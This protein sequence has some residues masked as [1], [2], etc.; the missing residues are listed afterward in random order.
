MILNKRSSIILSV[1]IVSVMFGVGLDYYHGS[2]IKTQDHPL[3][4][5]I[6]ITTPPS[7]SAVTING[8]LRSSFINAGNT[9][10]V[11]SW[12]NN[13]TF[14]QD[15]LLPTGEINVNGHISLIP[16]TS[17]TIAQ[18]NATQSFSG[19]NTMK[20]G[21]GGIIVRNPASTFTTNIEGGAVTANRTINLP[22]TTATDTFS[23]L[24]LAQSFSQT[25]TF[26]QNII[27]T[28]I[29]DIGASK[30]ACW[31]ST[32]TND[33]IKC[34]DAHSI[35]SLSST[36]STVNAT[37]GQLLGNGTGTSSMTMVMDGIYATITPTNTGRITVT[38]TGLTS[39]TV[40]GDGCIVSI[41]ESTSNMGINGALLAGNQLGNRLHTVEPVGQYRL[42]ISRAYEFAG[43]VGTQ[44]FFDL[45]FSAVVGGTCN[46][47]DI[48]W[49]LVEH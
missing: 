24:G 47:T 37:T 27:L 43:T 14:T 41:R 33:T 49:N 13:N 30:G 5:G 26:A 28:P 21:A 2:G 46:L 12:T 45:A 6:I 40:M 11:N 36:K 4:G 42:G 10:A 39:N 18:L 34:S 17:G 22:V 3:L 16:S 29:A 9:S 35:F 48:N 32:T 8:A 7:P 1:I 19:N 38:M 23:V 44:Y 31:F 25:I 20:F 15:L